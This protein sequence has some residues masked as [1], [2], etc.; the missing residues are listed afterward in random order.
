MT[1][2]DL[3]MPAVPTAEGKSG[4][5]YRSGPLPAPGHDVHSDRID[6]AAYGRFGNV[7]LYITE[8]CP[9]RCTHCS[10]DGRLGH[11]RTMGWS[12]ICTALDVW[13]RLGGSHA[14]ILGGE[15]A[16][17]PDFV[18]TLRYARTLGYQQ[19]STTINGLTPAARK[20]RGLAPT[21]LSSIQI[22]LDG[23]SH[24]THDQIHGPATF[25]TAMATAAD[26][27]DRGFDVW[28]LCTVTRTNRDDCLKLLDLAD[29]LG[30]TQVNYQLFSTIG[31]GHTHQAAAMTPRE[32][33]GF[34]QQLPHA[35]AGHHT[36]VCYQPT[37]GQPSTEQ[38]RTC[39]PRPPD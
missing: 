5:V 11:A 16:G 10:L 18:H 20:L 21:E 38:G 26:L 29:D 12:Q 27:T 39:P 33:I 4:N 17:H 6:R 3:S 30:I 2:T 25:A 14:T 34:Y 32:W 35:A 9:L 37:T 1:I 31:R 28:F 15:P 13:Q 22:S 23:G 8:A 7:D 36:R 19:V 24:L